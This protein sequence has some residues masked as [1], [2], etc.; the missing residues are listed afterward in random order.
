MFHVSCFMKIIVGLGNPGLKFRKTRH[1]IGFR[2]LDFLQKENNFPKFK[3][4]KKSKAEISKGVI[5]SQKVLL[6]KPQIFMNNSGFSVE[7]LC[8]TFYVPCSTLIVVHDDFDLPFG[9][10]KIAENSSSGG[11]RGV[12]S[13]IDNLKTQNF[14]RIRIGIRPSSRAGLTTGLRPANGN[15]VAANL[16]AEDFV[17]KKFSKAEE[18]NMAD[19]LEKASHN[20]MSLL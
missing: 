9:E 20:I 5:S 1:N 18:K 4:D 6:A 12:Q 10:I 8:S 19:L 13:I 14:K 2:F 7:A 3:L 11:H 15:P 16:K 17:L